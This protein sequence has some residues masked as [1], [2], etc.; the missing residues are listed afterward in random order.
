[1]VKKLNQKRHI[2]HGLLSFAKKTDSIDK[3]RQ[4]LTNISR[5][6]RIFLLISVNIN[7]I[8]G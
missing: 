1:M 8:F 5:S 7:Y 3:I 6:E 4:I 2:A